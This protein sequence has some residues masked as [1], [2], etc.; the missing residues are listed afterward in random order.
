[1]KNLPIV[2]MSLVAMFVVTMP[3]NEARAQ[4]GIGF[5]QQQVFGGG[6]N[7]FAARQIIVPQSTAFFSG[8]NVAFINQQAVG[9]GGFNN[10]AA[11][12]IIVPQ[13][14]AFFS[15]GNVAFVNQQ[16]VFNNFGGRR[17]VVGGG[18]RRNFINVGRLAVFVQ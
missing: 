17:A 5:N 6:F 3:S 10:F 14:T 16:Q 2:L 13:S 8:G 4:C 11:R 7:N 15:G 1:M 12:Q 9:G 18:G